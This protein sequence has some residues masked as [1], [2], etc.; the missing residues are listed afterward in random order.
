MQQAAIAHAAA[1]ERVGILR[2][3]LVTAVKTAW[4]DG[5]SVTDLAHMAGVSRKTIY[6]WLE[7]RSP[8]PEEQQ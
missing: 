1:V 5:D 8:E 4:D 6:E 2:G 7:E 3:Y